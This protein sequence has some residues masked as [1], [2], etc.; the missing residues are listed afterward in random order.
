VRLL[1]GALKVEFSVR[2]PFALGLADALAPRP[3]LAEPV[4]LGDAAIAP[5][6]RGRL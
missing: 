6:P 4:G 1:P 2:L 5:L 3:D